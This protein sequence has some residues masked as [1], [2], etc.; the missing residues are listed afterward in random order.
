MKKRKLAAAVGGIYLAAAIGMCT[1]DSVWA[2]KGTE[3]GQEIESEA[4]QAPPEATEIPS[5]EGE[6][7]SFPQFVNDQVYG[8]P[9]QEGI[10]VNSGETLLREGDTV[11]LL[12]AYNLPSL[13][14]MSRE[15]SD[16]YMGNLQVLLRIERL[17]LDPASFLTP[18]YDWKACYADSLTKVGEGVDFPEEVEYTGDTASGLNDFLEDKK[19]VTIHVRAEHLILDETVRVPSDVALVGNGTRVS[20][21]ASGEEPAYAFLVEEAENVGISGFILEGG[22]GQGIYI[23]NS[24]RCLIRENEITEA[25]YKAVCVMAEG[26]YINLVNNSIHDNGNGAIFL[27]GDISNCI[28]QGNEVYQNRGTRNLTAGIVFSAMEVEDPYTPYNEFKDEHLYDQLKA[29]HQNIIMDNHIQGNYSSGF[30]C[31]G[32]Y[33]NYC[34]GNLI[35]DN[36]KEGMCLDYGTFGTYVSGNTV[37][38]NGNRNRQTDEDLEAD[39][40]LGAGRLSDGSSTAKLPGISIDNSAYNIVMENRVCDNAGSGIKMVRSAYRNL[41]LGNVVGDNNRG[42]NDAFHGFGIEFGHASD[43]DEPVV[44]LDF[45]ADYE[46][47]AARNVISGGHYA[48]IFFGEGSYCNDLIDNVVMDS[49]LFSIENH[50]QLYNSSIGNTVNVGVLDYNL[51][52]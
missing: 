41:I 7:R 23:L 29:P 30:Y 11:S 24:H 50:S 14:R 48:G 33:L 47:I 27:D 17:G 18:E 46:N 26:S 2:D 13:E 32:G 40:I 3:P 39:F 52:Q 34:M 12:E 44:G 35:E 31:D 16:K 42:R 28:I 49:E 45:T 22:F 21:E 25:T 19:G 37:R 43:P 1:W 38:R 15:D 10:Y 20:G 6:E 51:N 5:K 36:E 9:G 4:T 8:A